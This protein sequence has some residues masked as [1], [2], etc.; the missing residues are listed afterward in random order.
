MKKPWRR[1]RG[2][3]R[4]RAPVLALLV[5]SAA[6]ALAPA[7]ETGACSLDGATPATVAAVD[8]HFE[9]LLDDGRRGALAGIDVAAGEAAAA[10]RRL[11]DWLAGADV[12]VGPLA[13]G[14]DRW[15]RV[16]MR[17]FAA[18]ASDPQAPLV[19]VGA[20]LLEEGLARF[21]PDP[22]AADCA[23]AYLA[24]E[25]AAREAGRGAWSREPAFQLGR[26]PT[27]PL[28]RRK[29]LTIVEGK[30]RDVGET[31]AA[32]YLNFGEN[33]SSGA[34]VMISRRNL[35]ILEALGIER[36]ELRGRRVRVRGLIE[37][38]FGPRIDI[39]APAQ[40]ELLP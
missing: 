17:V 2:W 37:T 31:R 11:S 23:P 9:L 3:F 25:A 39:I 15:G 26:D 34:S 28:M 13:S 1:G 21:R 30:I 36:H 12:F 38:G 16:P 18:V 35:A 5:P 10:R 29:G 22:P 14:S 6:I 8:D 27:A 40:L 33:A 24:A 20:A 32:V 7:P 19:S 4:R